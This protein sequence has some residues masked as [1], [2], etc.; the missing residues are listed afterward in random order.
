MPSLHEITGLD[1]SILQKKLRLEPR[2]SF[3]ANEPDN[4]VFMSPTILLEDD[5]L[6]FG[7]RK[8][9]GAKEFLGLVTKRILKEND[10]SLFKVPEI[11]STHMGYGVKSSNKEGKRAIEQAEADYWMTKLTA[12]KTFD[13]EHIN[14]DIEVPNQENDPEAFEESR[15]LI[16]EEISGLEIPV[17][18]SYLL[19]FS[20]LLIYFGVKKP[21]LESGGAGNIGPNKVS[22]FLIFWTLPFLLNFS[23]RK[24]SEI[25]RHWQNNEQDRKFTAPIVEKTVEEVIEHACESINE[26]RSYVDNLLEVYR[27]MLGS[28]AID[29]PYR[30]LAARDGSPIILIPLKYQETKLPVELKHLGSRSTWS[31][32]GRTTLLKEFLSKFVKNKA[33][34]KDIFRSMEKEGKLQ[35]IDYGIILPDHATYNLFI[36]EVEKDCQDLFTRIPARGHIVP[37]CGV[38]EDDTNQITLSISYLPGKSL[39]VHVV[40]CFWSSIKTFGLTAEY[41]TTIALESTVH[42]FL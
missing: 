39:S 31:K 36:G 24:L 6:R 7:G 26:T 38:I 40:A 8:E 2:H 14:A 34:Q 32:L 9:R 13:A 28:E 17:K 21:K 27:N 5:Q 18:G 1:D 25:E 29:K 4:L 23:S 12:V 10:S 20:I 11:T 16:S 41:P 30:L 42:I 22:D 33:V 19:F 35:G 3:G 37:H 15:D